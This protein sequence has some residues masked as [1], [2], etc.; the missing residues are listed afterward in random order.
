MIDNCVYAGVEFRNRLQ[1]EF[2]GI[3]LPNSMVFDYPTIAAAWNV[4]SEL[5]I[6]INKTASYRFFY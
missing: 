1:R 2:D 4:L 6:L 5:T 3:N